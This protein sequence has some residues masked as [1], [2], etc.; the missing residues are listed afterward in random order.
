VCYRNYNFPPKE[1]I[2]S[3][4]SWIKNYPTGKLKEFLYFQLCIVKYTLDRCSPENGFSFKLKRL[5]VK[6]PSILLNQLGFMPNWERE[7]LWQ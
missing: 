6:Y 2:K 3:N 1:L 7:H 4:H 5:I